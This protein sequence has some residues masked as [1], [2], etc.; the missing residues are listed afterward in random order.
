MDWALREPFDT[1]ALMSEI[2][3][4]VVIAHA[5]NDW[6]IPMTHSDTLFDA[7][8][9]EETSMETRISGFGRMYET[10]R[11]DMRVVLVKTAEGGHNMI[12]TLEGVQ[13]VIRTVFT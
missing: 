11:D 4:S 6:E 3:S 8:R 2:K 10:K 5:E 7:L 9:R 12:G 13:D 1:L